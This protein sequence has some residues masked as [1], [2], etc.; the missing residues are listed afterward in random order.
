[1]NYDEKKFKGRNGDLA[2]IY[3]IWSPTFLPSHLNWSV[4]NTNRNMSFA[5]GPTCWIS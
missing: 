3:Q 2:K 1:M 4:V 5:D